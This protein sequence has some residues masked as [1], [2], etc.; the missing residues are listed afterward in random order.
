MGSLRPKTWYLLGLMALLPFI[1]GCARQARQPAASVPTEVSE[2]SSASPDLTVPPVTAAES[3][4]EATLLLATAPP[5]EFA[6]AL[7]PYLDTLPDVSPT[8]L[9]SAEANGLRLV[10]L[11]LS[12]WPRVA[13]KLRLTGAAQRLWLPDRGEW[14]EIMRGPD[15]ASSRGQVIALDA[16]RLELPAGRLRLLA[17]CWL[18]P[19]APGELTGSSSNEPRAE[20]RIELIP[21]LQ[22]VNATARQ[23]DE[24]LI[25]APPRA[26]RPIEQGM[27]F[28]RLTLNM[29]ARHEPTAPWICL[30]VAERPGVDWRQLAAPRPESTEDEE[31]E[32]P[33]PAVGQV[34]RS[35][36]RRRSE[37]ES[38]DSGSAMGGAG[39]SAADL[40]TLG[41]ALFGGAA[42]SDT[43]GGA[44]G[45]PRVVLVL[46]PRVPA[47]FNLLAP[48]AAP[49]PAGTPPAKPAANQTREQRKPAG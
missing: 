2:F 17:R 37:P 44:R 41:E 29:R 27:T 36:D 15:R 20:L 18:T 40:P 28:P 10:R 6:Q 46:T 45:G 14:T 39:P 26:S 49:P 48:P 1:D 3:G 13:E 32:R 7:L 8:A 24:F 11:P 5:T 23:R 31:P 4:V 22:D 42:L 9:A 16:E 34:V 35:G 30:A 12:E 33:T 21:Q 43:D 19:I 25:D 47:A 38:R